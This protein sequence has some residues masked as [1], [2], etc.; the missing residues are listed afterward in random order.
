MVAVAGGQQA[1]HEAVDPDVVDHLADAGGIGMRMDFLPDDITELAVGDGMIRTDT[2]GEDA[3]DDRDDNIPLMV[4][5]LRCDD[6]ETVDHGLSSLSPD[7]QLVVEIQLVP[8]DNLLNALHIV[9]GSGI[10]AFLQGD[11][12]AVVVGRVTLPAF[13][14][15][16]GH[17]QTAVM[18]D[19]LLDGGIVAELLVLAV[20]V[21][22]AVG[23]TLGKPLAGGLDTE[24]VLAATGKVAVAVAG[25]PGHLGEGD[26]GRDAVFLLVLHGDTRIGLEEVGTVLELHQ[27]GRVPAGGGTSSGVCLCQCLRHGGRGAAKGLDG[28][29]AYL[30]DI[31]EQE[32]GVYPVAVTLGGDMEVRAGGT[33]CISRDPDDIAREDGSA[34]GDAD[35]GEMA[36][37]DGV[38]AVAQDDVPAAA[39]VT[40]YVFN[41]AVEH[42]HDGLVVRLQVKARMHGTLAG[43][44]VLALPVGG[45]DGHFLQRV[46][47]AHVA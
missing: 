31:P 4:G 9:L 5:Y 44:R 17:Q 47:H 15:A 19:A 13:P 34:L 21:M 41:D 12:P 30:A 16:V 24:E 25:L 20:I 36:V 2:R 45:C 23:L 32:Q 14:V 33:A 11:E 7:G 1:G 10:A 8:R 43:E 40:A 27:R 29:A 18:V 37:A 22:D 6:L 38:E 39:G 46:A 3:G 35:V 42:A 28:L 26:A